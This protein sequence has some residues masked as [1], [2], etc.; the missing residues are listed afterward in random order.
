V[1]LR[2]AMVENYRERPCVSLDHLQIWTIE[3]RRTHARNQPFV[4]LST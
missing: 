3:N 2:F 1:Y 4:T